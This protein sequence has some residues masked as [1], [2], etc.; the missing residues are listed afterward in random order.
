MVDQQDKPRRPPTKIRVTKLQEAQLHDLDM[1]EQA[2]AAQLHSVGVGP[3]QVSPRSEVE[4]ARL[5]R[6]HDVLVAE[7]DHE[8]AGYMAWADEAPGVAWL[9]IFM[10]APEYQRFGVATHMLRELGEITSGLNI[11]TVVTGAWERAP[12]SLA[13]LGVRGFQMLEVGASGVPEKLASWASRR[14]PELSEPGSRLW[15]A[16]TDGLGTIPGLPRPPAS[17]R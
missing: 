16:R 9:P 3:S 8:V 17:S 4:I 5:T 11:S 15:W 1:L 7:A 14:V 6:D 2:C 12:W 10:V 13:F